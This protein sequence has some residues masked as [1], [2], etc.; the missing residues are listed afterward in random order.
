[1]FELFYSF[2]HLISS[3]DI[4]H[5]FKFS[6]LLFVFDVYIVPFPIV[7]YMPMWLFICWCTAYELYT[8]HCGLSSSLDISDIA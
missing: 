7:K 5:R 6:V 2:S 1:M 8:R 4:C 3:I